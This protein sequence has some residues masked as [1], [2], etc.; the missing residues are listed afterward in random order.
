MVNKSYLLF[1]F[2]TDRSKLFEV[3]YNISFRFD[4]F[5]TFSVQYQYHTESFLCLPLS[6]CGGRIVKP[7][8][9]LGDG[10]VVPTIATCYLQSQVLR[11]PSLH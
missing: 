4:I 5:S 3:S 9:V 6:D 1:G 8:K 10:T 11:D 7:W 2:G